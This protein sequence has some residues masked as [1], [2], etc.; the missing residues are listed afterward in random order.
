MI[1]REKKKK[2]EI[3]KITGYLREAF[4]SA[5]VMSG[6]GVEPSPE[7]VEHLKK[8]RRMKR[9]IA[10]PS[11]RAVLVKRSLNSLRP[12][13]SDYHHFITVSNLADKGMDAYSGFPKPPK[14]V[15][16][17]LAVEEPGGGGGGEEALDAL[18]DRDRDRDK[19]SEFDYEPNPVDKMAIRYMK[20][21]PDSLAKKRFL[22][23]K[24]KEYKH[25]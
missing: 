15:Y 5:P 20:Q 2:D 14:D 8:V 7:N 9:A 6:G 18:K 3:D 23:K 25:G 1:K 19:Y 10:S 12:L 21:S 24:I 13:V 11:R 4:V 22:D 17:R 16:R